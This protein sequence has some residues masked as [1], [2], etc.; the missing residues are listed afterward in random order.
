M[1]NPTLSSSES[2]RLGMMTMSAIKSKKKV[3][4]RIMIPQKNGIV[5]TVTEKINVRLSSYTSGPG[6]IAASHP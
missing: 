4:K 5:L 3:Q 1:S 2:A 6:K